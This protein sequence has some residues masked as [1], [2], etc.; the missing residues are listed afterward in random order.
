M[1][2]RGARFHSSVAVRFSVNGVFTNFARPASRGPEPAANP[3]GL[4]RSVLSATST[5]LDGW[6]DP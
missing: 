4:N 6:E 1:V 5:S 2:M 3:G